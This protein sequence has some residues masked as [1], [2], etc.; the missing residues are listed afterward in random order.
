M[1]VQDTG[2]HVSNI[3]KVGKYGTVRKL[4][5]GGLFYL[6]RAVERLDFRFLTWD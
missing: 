2:M 6:G 1:M 3:S 4:L 5:E